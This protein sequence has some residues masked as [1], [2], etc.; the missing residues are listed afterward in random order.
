MVLSSTPSS[1]LNA[2]RSGASDAIAPMFKSLLACGSWSGPLEDEQE[3]ITELSV[4]VVRAT[5]G[6]FPSRGP[7]R[8]KN[9]FPIAKTIGNLP[10][11]SR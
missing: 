1:F 4:T 6:Y 2:L 10:S 9:L 3:E 8:L 5:S 7:I 11:A